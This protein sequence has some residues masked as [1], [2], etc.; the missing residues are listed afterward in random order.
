MT[1]GRGWESAKYGTALGPIP[2]VTCLKIAMV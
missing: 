1:N 2:L